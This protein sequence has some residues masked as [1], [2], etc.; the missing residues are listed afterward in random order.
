MAEHIRLKVI[1]TG[2]EP[3][4]LQDRTGVEIQLAGRRIRTWVSPRPLHISAQQRQRCSSS[5]CRSYPGDVDIIAEAEGVRRLVEARR[6]DG[7]MMHAFAFLGEE[8]RVDARV[9][10]RLD[11]LPH[12]LADQGGRETPGAFDRLAVLAQILRV[13]GA[14]LVDLPRAEPVIVDVRPQRCVKVA[15]DY[16]DLHRFG[17]DRLAHR[18]IPETRS[19]ARFPFAT[20]SAQPLIT[21]D[22]FC[23]L[24]ISFCCGHS[25]IA[26]DFTGG[27]SAH[28]RTEVKEHPMEK[29]GKNSLIM[30]APSICH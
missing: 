21:C 11:Q 26:T 13:R 16:P 24:L 3:H 1:C 19:C 7:D 20:P 14:E 23:G 12:H 6:G 15:H 17:E 2:R 30:K 9:V 5:G 4:A 10:E 27:T 28:D 18:P 22:E 8:A 29:G 25:S